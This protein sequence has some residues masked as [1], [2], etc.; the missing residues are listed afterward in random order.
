MKVILVKNHPSLGTPGDVL[1]VADGY[2]RNFLLVN[3]L[4]V[5]AT[6]R[7]RQEWQ[8]KKAAQG[9]AATAAMQ[10]AK[11]VAKELAGKRVVITVKANDRGTLFAAI[12]P[13][14]I[15]AA[16]STEYVTVEPQWLI[17][18]APLKQIGSHQISFRVAGG[19]TGQFTVVIVAAPAA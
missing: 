2:A 14:Q 16:A 17:V 9:R 13:N 5:A 15:A 18:V 19:Q 11:R 10:G 8:E 4:A 12:T 1:D 6:G 3:G 7:A